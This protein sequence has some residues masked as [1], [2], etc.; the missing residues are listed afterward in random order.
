MQSEQH[1]RPV[2]PPNAES[3]DDT[4]SEAGQA[5]GGQA[6]GG[7]TKV[8]PP[9]PSKALPT[10][11]MK[12]EVQKKALSAIAILSEYGKRGISG[13]DMAPRLEV[14]A[15]TAG[16]N[17]SFFA[18]SKLI[19]RTGKG[20]FKSTD[21]A[22]EFARRFSFNQEEA[23]LCL[24]EPL[25]KTWYFKTVSQ[26]ISGFGP[27]PKEKLIEL[28][29]YDAETTKDYRVH[30]GTLLSWLE[31]AGLIKLEDGKYQLTANAPEPGTD[32]GSADVKEEPKEP[33]KET[34]PATPEGA[35]SAPD[36][37]GQSQPANA[38]LGFNFDFT[39]TGDQLAKLSPEQI[40][41]LFK[42]VGDVMAIKA[43]VSD[44]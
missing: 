38:I 4:G 3:T 34:P 30:L 16:L 43:T 24:K 40:T 17:N 8:R 39:L 19:E 23:G 32:R 6:G 41:A 13:A 21:A 1:L 36:S 15:T 5:G 10:D 31:Y 2:P 22:N 29:A 28:L 20:R 44:D 35:T 33:E 42:A 9:R 26:Q 11:R 25:S 12:L 37:G 18:Q 27:T 7:A 14:A